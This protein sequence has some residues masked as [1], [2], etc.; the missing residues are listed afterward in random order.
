ISIDIGGGVNNTGSASY[1]AEVDDL[2]PQL[3]T[4]ECYHFPFVYAPVEKGSEIGK[5]IIKYKEK[6]VASAPIV[7]EESVEYY[8]KQE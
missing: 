1:S 6:E 5:I 4:E 8:A 2:D 7:A 3:V